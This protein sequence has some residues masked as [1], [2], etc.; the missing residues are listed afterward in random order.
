MYFKR[1]NCVFFSIVDIIV[2]MKAMS[3]LSALYALFLS[4]VLY[5][6]KDWKHCLLCNMCI[7]FTRCI[8]SSPFPQNMLSLIYNFSALCTLLPCYICSLIYTLF[9]FLSVVQFVSIESHV[10]YFHI[11]NIVIKVHLVCIVHVAS[12]L[13]NRIVV[14]LVSAELVV[15]FIK[16]VLFMQ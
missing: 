11:L 15:S 5:E 9:V 12:G 7:I 14:P 10:L 8:F 13:C 1:L 6:L 4:Y 3:L 2:A 16:T